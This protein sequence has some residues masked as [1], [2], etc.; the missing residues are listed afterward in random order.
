MYQT[1]EVRG[2]AN[3][4][5]RNLPLLREAMQELGIDGLLVPHDDE[6]LNE[7]LPPQFERLCWA[8]GFSGSAGS[9][10]VMPE[11]AVLFIDGRY[12]EQARLETPGELFEYEDFRGT[13]PA[14]WLAQ[15]PG[16]VRKLG[17]ATKLHTRQEIAK[18][19]SLESAEPVELVALDEHPVDAL[20]SDRPDVTPGDPYPHPIEFAGESSSDRR[21]KIA[22]SLKNVAADCVVFTNPNASAWLFNLRGSDVPNTPVALCRAVVHADGSAAAVLSGHRVSDELRAHLG[23]SVEII[24]ETGYVDYLRTIGAAG[25]TVLMDSAAC[26]DLVYRTLKE[27]G[28]E[29]REGGDPLIPLRGVKNEAEIE[30]SRNAHVRDGVAMVKFL[31]WLG[32]NGTS[33]ISEIDAVKRLEAFRSEDPAMRGISFDT[34]SGS[35]P[36]GAIIHYRVSEASNR[37]MGEGELFLVD[38]GAQYFDGTTDITR[39]MALGEPSAEHRD[40]FT[41]VLQGHIALA[42]AVFPPDTTGYQLDML[43][44]QPLWNAGLDY[45]HGT[46]HGIGTY[47]GVHEG[48]QSIAK[49]AATVP[50]Q[51]GMTITIEPGFYV[52]GEYGIRIENVAVVR[53]SA[54]FEGML[55]FDALTMTPMDK[56]LI[57][58][59]LMSDSDLDWLNRYHDAVREALAPHL[60]GADLEWLEDATAPLTR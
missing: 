8:T 2:D 36:N 19:E 52:E 45:A 46:G 31:R 7:Y 27:A 59:P 12:T 33:G 54:S 42:S 39:T 23:E 22:E 48:P 16:R 40:R 47:L 34:I 57:D 21:A 26:P 25:K 35:G 44:R 41:R 4:A 37:V 5:V 55:E 49:R 15:N 56:T 24:D 29:I 20:W 3:A 28:A 13:P 9:L 1:F 32:E 43:A 38:S 30:G 50:L 60:D 14:D 51:A 58:V 11:T 53:E 10:I 18:I 6:Y 17:Y